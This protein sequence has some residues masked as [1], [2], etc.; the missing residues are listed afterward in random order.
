MNNKLV[1]L[2]ILRGLS[3]WMVVYYHYMQIFYGFQSNSNLGMFFSDFGMLG[4][5]IFFVLSG[6]IMARSLTLFR[7][8]PFDFFISRF[9]RIT[10]TYWFFTIITV[11]V[12][13]IFQSRFLLSDYSLSSLCLSLFYISNNNPGGTGCFPTLTVGWT[14]NYEMFFYL[15]LSF[16]LMVNRSAALY[17]CSFFFILIFFLNLECSQC[18]CIWSRGDLLVEF[19]LGII[20]AKIYILT[21]KINHRLNLFIC[22][23]SFVLCLLLFPIVGMFLKAKLLFCTLIVY[24][25]AILER[26]CKKNNRLVIGLCFLGDISYSTYLCHVPILYVSYLLIPKYSNSLVEII[27]ILILTIFIVIISWLSF[28]IIETNVSINRLKYFLI[29]KTFIK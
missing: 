19:S 21:T 18:F 10:P 15:V 11:V 24:L 14:L 27:I 8:H 22:G 28:R 3:A 6:F 17:I 1:L 7:R 23:I 25:F 29:Q 16:S 4:V 12:I 26:H 13:E 9:L 20:L 2:Q 5:D